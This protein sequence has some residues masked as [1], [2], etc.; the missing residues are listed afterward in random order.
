VTQ[1]GAAGSRDPAGFV[2]QREGQLLRQVNASYRES[3]GRVLASGVLDEL[4]TA[5]L[6]IPHEVA[7]IR[8]AATEDAWQ[9]LRPERVRFISYP[10]E[11]SFSQLRDA[12]L[13]TLDVQA[14]AL[15][16]GV[17]LRDASAYN[18][19]F[20]RG[21]PVFID[22]LSFGPYEEGRPWVAYRQFCEHFLAPLALMARCDVRLAG[23]HA[24]FADG[25]PLDLA[26]RLLGPSSWL[27]PSLALHVHMHARAQRRYADAAGRPA[28][29]SARLTRNALLR[30]VE[31]LRHTIEAL[32]WE[33]AGTTWAEY[34]TTH[35]YSGDA[36]AAKQMLVRGL[37]ST[38]SPKMTWDLGANTGRFSRIAADLGSQVIAIDGDYAAVDR[39]YR[40]ERARSGETIL[41]LVN[42]LLVPSAS[43]GWAGAER[44]SL[45]ERGPA[46][47]LLALAVV[48]HIAFSGNIAL[49]RIA[50]WFAQLGRAG[51]VEFI[52]P[53]DPQVRR[54]TAA[55]PEATHA[56]DREAFERAFS[57]RFTISAR[58]PVPETGRVL[59]LMRRNDATAA[60]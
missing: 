14:R 39:A 12:A 56:S 57:R 6:L 33:P 44:Q 55:R 42:D 41:P 29:G 7:P 40:A 27:R 47:A 53:D 46:D 26:S 28:R 49:P 23:L 13:L 36:A 43:S 16:R 54:L 15:T 51:I 3:F 52:P 21:R 32:R 45:I 59:Y 34:E 9:V 17:T 48:H 60:T 10:Y 19:Q 1:A 25:I 22:T 31:Q 11:W 35:G 58:R 30:L 4:Q 50:D 20:H 24:Q 8:L 5:G 2:Y 37:L 18:V 38:L